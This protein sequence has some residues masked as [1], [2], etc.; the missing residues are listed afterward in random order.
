[1]SQRTMATLEARGIPAF[2]EIPD[3][4]GHAFDLFP[5]EDRKGLGWA[6]IERAYAFARRQLGMNVV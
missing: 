6:S 4:C 3:G 5:V 1:M 2:F